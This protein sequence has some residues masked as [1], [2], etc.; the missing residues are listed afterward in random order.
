M[1]GN[2]NDSS[3]NNTPLTGR[4]IFG[5]FMCLFYVAIGCLFI[6]QVF[7]FFNS[8]ILGYI[9]GGLLVLYGIWR[10]Y[11]MYKGWN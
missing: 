2:N 9:L 1:K 10:G 3:H 6:F 4:I 5:I 8:P 7:P 11:R